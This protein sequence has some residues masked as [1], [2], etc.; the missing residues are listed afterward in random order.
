MRAAPE[1]EIVERR[2]AAEGVSVTVVNL[3]PEG[4]ATSLTA[5]VLVSASPTVAFEHCAAYGRRNVTSSA[6]RW[7]GIGYLGG[8][9]WPGIGCVGGPRRS[10]I[11]C[12]A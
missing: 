3:Q 6:P 7:R 12:D 4:F 5:V 10:G 8:S 11:R 9:R 1:L 2:R